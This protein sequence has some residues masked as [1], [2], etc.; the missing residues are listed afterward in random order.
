MRVLVTGGGGFIGSTVVD[1]LIAHGHEVLAV[2]DLSAGSLTNL[3]DA[4]RDARI[5]FHRFDICSEGFGD[6]VPQ[7][8]PE[9]VL[10]LAAQASVPRSVADP[11]IDAQVNIMGLLR[12]LDACVASSVR[13]IVF[14]SSGGTIYGTQ[15][16]LPI[17]ETAVGRPLS[18]YGIT[19][20]AGEDYLRFYEAEYGLDFTSLALANVYGPRQDPHGEGSVVSRFALRLIEGQ[21]PRID[22]TGEQTRDFV[23]VDDVANAFVRACDAGSGETINISTGVETSITELYREMAEATS[24]TGEPEY[25][26][27]RPGDVLRSA[28]D[29]SKAAKVLEWRPWTT[30]EEGVKRTI[31]WFDHRSG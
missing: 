30:L 2:D 1:L 27:A 14:S 23:F 15:R 4:R 5:K 26:P 11:M 13:K 8:K 6:L 31:A 17:N 18:P 9:V 21:P 3:D 10:H 22:G 12:V 24:F 28:L 7:V 20:K 25:G 29:P 19:K 16:K